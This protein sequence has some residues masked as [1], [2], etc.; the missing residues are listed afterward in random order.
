MDTVEY[1]AAVDIGS[2]FLTHD[3]IQSDLEKCKRKRAEQAESRKARS[4]FI[5]QLETINSRLEACGQAA[6]KL[7]ETF[8]TES[9]W[10]GSITRHRYTAEEVAKAENKAVKAEA[11]RA[12]REA[13]ATWKAGENPEGASRL[14]SRMHSPP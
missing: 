4:E 14:R 10:G 5:G 1:D 7:G 12:M 11:D 8:F 3:S 9:G 13:E 2:L 6:F